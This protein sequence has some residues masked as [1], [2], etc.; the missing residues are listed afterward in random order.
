M[1]IIYAHHD[2][3]P[4]MALP[5]QCLGGWLLHICYSVNMHRQKH[6]KCKQTM[7]E[8]SAFCISKTQHLQ[9]LTGK[10]LKLYHPVST[11]TSTFWKR[12]MPSF[13]L[14]NFLAT[15][16]QAKE[17]GKRGLFPVMQG[18]PQNTGIGVEDL[19]LVSSTDRNNSRKKCC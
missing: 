18:R 17:P 7:L 8:I 6:K 4:I 13:P 9:E 5:S 2:Q 11:P 19:Y 3:G 15:A 16:C 10:S 14:A 12:I 1:A